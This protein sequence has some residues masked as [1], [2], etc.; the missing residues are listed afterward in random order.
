[1]SI[2]F[3]FQKDIE[4]EVLYL[5][6]TI[7]AMYYPAEPSTGTRAT[8]EIIGWYPT[9]GARSSVPTYLWEAIKKWVDETYKPKWE[10][11]ALTVALSMGMS[12]HDAPIRSP[13]TLR[14]CGGHR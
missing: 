7:E 2:S 10:D 3:I 8:T 14:G 5:E 6:C 1:M 4:H 13:F 11:E 9:D 12:R